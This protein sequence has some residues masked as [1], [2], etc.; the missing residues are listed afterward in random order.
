MNKTIDPKVW[1]LSKNKKHRLYNNTSPITH[2]QPNTH[3]TINNNREVLDND[4]IESLL[5]HGGLVHGMAGT[6]KSTT[7]KKFKEHIK[8]GYV[9]GA[10]THKASKIVKGKTLHNLLGIDTKTNNIDY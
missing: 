2:G 5:K 6:G 1:M 7:L 10:F 9:T 4:D 3:S 8:E